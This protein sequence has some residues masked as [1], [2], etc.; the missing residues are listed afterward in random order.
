MARATIT[1][2]IT[3]TDIFKFCE[4]DINSRNFSEG[5]AVFT[6]GHVQLVGETV[7][8]DEYTIN[9]YGLVVQTTAL[10]DAHE[11]KGT[12]VKEE[13]LNSKQDMIK[14]KLHLEQFTCSCK[15]GAGEKCKHIVAV[16]LWLYQ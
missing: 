15:A 12:I 10:D 5:E 2:Q 9:I 13:S 4:C 11:V 6:A 7:S 1:R 3:I 16:L 8:D 14:T